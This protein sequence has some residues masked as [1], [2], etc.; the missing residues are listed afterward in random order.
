MADLMTLCSVKE[1]GRQSCRLWTHLA[2]GRKAIK[3]GGNEESSILS[4]CCVCVSAARALPAPLDFGIRHICSPVESSIVCG[5]W[6]PGENTEPHMQLLPRSRGRHHRGCL[7]YAPCQPMGRGRREEP[8]VVPGGS[9]RRK[10]CDDLSPWQRG[11]QGQRSPRAAGEGSFCGSPCTHFWK[12]W[13]NCSHPFYMLQIL[14]RAG[15]HVLS[16]DYR[17]FGDSTG[18]P[19]ESGLT[20]DALYLYEWVKRHSGGSLVCMWGHSLGSGVATNAA[21]KVQERGSSL[22]ALI[23][24]APFT[25][26]GEVVAVYPL[27]KLYTFLPGFEDFLWDTLEANNLVFANDDNVK[28]LTC[29]LLILHAEDDD[30]V[31]YHMGQKL[32]QVSLRAHPERHTEM[33]SYKAS[34]GF[35]H[36]DIYLDPNLPESVG[37]FL[38]TLGG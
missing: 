9:W 27:T 33:I 35:S 10:P 13:V 36:C 34:H 23:L 38:K 7:A 24:E 8:R 12:V 11:E 2:I 37:D 25:R 20:T 14:S 3:H 21:V 5:S 32:Y 15:F 17:G 16:L 19:S 18:Q 31:P 28:A 26:I 1:P 6:P 4:D 22:D 29:P 30:I